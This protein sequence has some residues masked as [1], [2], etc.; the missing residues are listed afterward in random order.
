MNFRR[1]QTFS[2]GKRENKK[3]KEGKRKGERFLLNLLTAVV[4]ETTTLF[5]LSC[6]H[7]PIH[8]F[9]NRLH[10][11]PQL[12]LVPKP[13]AIGHPWPL[14]SEKLPGPSSWTLLLLMHLGSPTTCPAESPPP[15][16]TS[17]MAL[18]LSFSPSHLWLLSPFI[19]L[20]HQY[21]LRF[22]IPRLWEWL[23]KLHV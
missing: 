18:L 22:Q 20:P 21:L 1:A 17:H 19:S 6:L 7:C 10:F 16:C 13:L 3:G 14:L 8:C 12:L 23:L 9:K 2:P 15:N 11:L 4:P 5:F